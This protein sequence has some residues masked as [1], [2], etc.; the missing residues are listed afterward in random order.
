MIKWVTEK[1][2]EEIKT[3]LKLNKNE[4]TTY[5]NL[6]DRAKQTKKRSWSCLW[7]GLIPVR[8]GRRWGKGMEGEYGANTVHT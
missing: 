4:N 7:W 2:R 6:W 1:I 3:F 8:G 5:E